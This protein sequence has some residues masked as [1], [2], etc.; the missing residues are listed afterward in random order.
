MNRISILALLLAS[1]CSGP[2]PESQRPI[3]EEHL[4]LERIEAAEDARVA[5]APALSKGAASAEAQIRTRAA[6]ALGRILRPEGIA[7]LLA[8][9]KDPDASVRRAAIF[10]LGQYGFDAEG[11]GG[12]EG[13]MMEA[14]K[15]ALVDA[16]VRLRGAAVEAIGKLA[17]EKAPDM[18]APFLADPSFAVRGQAAIACFRW[19]RVLVMRR[20]ESKLPPLSVDALGELGI[21]ASDANGEVRWRVAYAL[22]RIADPRSASLLPALMRDPH[23]LA[24]LF[25][26]NAVERIKEKSLAETVAGAQKDPD[27]AVRQAAL[28]ALDALERPDLLLE[29]LAGDPSHH[30]R[31][32][33]ADAL[34]KEGPVLEE[35]AKDPSPTVRSAALFAKVRVRKE[36]ALG[37]LVAAFEG[38]DPILKVAAVKGAG[39]LKEAGLELLWRALED[40]LEDLRAAALVSMAETPGERAF[41]AI[42]K[43]LGAK[44]LAERATAVESLS[45]RK[46]PETISAAADCY[47]ASLDR[48]WVEVRESIVDLLANWIPPDATTAHLLEICR[49]DPG[50]SVRAKAFSALRRRG[51]TDLP[52]VPVGGI[53]RSPHFGLRFASNP[54]V[55]LETSKGEVEIECLARQAP[56]HVAN[57]VGLVEKGF[58]D[59]LKWHRVVPNFV[60]Q[61]GDPLGNGWGDAGW[62]V[63][64]EINTVP[65]ERGT[66]GM[67]RSAGFDTGGC[68]IFI[69]HLPTPHLDGLYTVFGRVVKGLDVVDRIEVGDRILRA[70]VKR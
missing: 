7:P 6:V 59:G 66:V 11:A 57:F 20:P 65:Y 61:G 70:T 2:A 68:Q 25:A 9:A 60:I 47:R 12:R 13:E 63:R 21:A 44:G 40:P 27:A 62:S 28:R 45:K 34:E 22:S 33:F 17:L 26:L 41:A 54:I 50:P 23:P 3:P 56:V 69:T 64:A 30:V 67:P 55:T 10:A 5:D 19:R 1:A 43:G 52:A 58:Y 14:I 53:T 46:E 8:L 31:E 49:A 16:N 24:R 37:D 18:A 38:A 4:L 39:H 35:L 51:M 36:G 48:E 32:A 15:P 29:S 42:R